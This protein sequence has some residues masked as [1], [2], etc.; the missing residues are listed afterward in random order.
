M[1]YRLR[2][3]KNLL[4]GWTHCWDIEAIFDRVLHDE[5]KYLIKNELPG[6]ILITSKISHVKIGS[7]QY[8]TKKKKLVNEMTGSV[9]YECAIGPLLYTLQTNDLP[10]DEDTSLM[11]AFGDDIIVL[12]VS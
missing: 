8:I 4:F 2:W 11:V 12:A 6:T 1:K 10:P 3:K 9:P 7:R 5:L